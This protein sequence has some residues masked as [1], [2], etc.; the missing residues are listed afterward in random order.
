MKIPFSPLDLPNSF[1]L[2]KKILFQSNNEI[3]ET[4]HTTA[5]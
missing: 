4:N 5:I 1:H 3:C 2:M